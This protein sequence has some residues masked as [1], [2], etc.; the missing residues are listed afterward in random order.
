MPAS[1]ARLGSCCV[2]KLPVWSSSHG[3]TRNHTA[4]STSSIPYG[5][6]NECSAVCRA[7]LRTKTAR[8]TRGHAGP[9][10]PCWPCWR[11]AA[12][13]LSFFVSG[14]FRVQ[15]PQ[16]AS[17]NICG[18]PGDL[19]FSLLRV[20]CGI[21]T[22]ARLGEPWFVERVGLGEGRKQRDPGAA[23]HTYHVLFCRDM[24]DG[25]VMERRDGASLPRCPGF[26]SPPPALPGCA[27]S[28]DTS[29]DK[30]EYVTL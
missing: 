13:T 24:G 21:A 2:Y 12:K 1:R 29:T 18:L 25:I 26:L 19:P 22:K 7:G 5:T 11:R 6:K 15:L 23:I 30:Q 9:A 27:A 3:P 28:T 8:S 14:A 10:G 17:S 4:S 16:A 20:R